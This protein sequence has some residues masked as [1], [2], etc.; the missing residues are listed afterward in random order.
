MAAMTE[1]L[2]LLALGVLFLLGLAVDA[3][4]RRVH[5]P[6]VTL[7]IILGA[8]IGP[9]GLDILPPPLAHADG[10]YAS[11]ALTMVAFLLGGS[12]KLQTLRAHGVRIMVLSLSVVLSSV[13]LVAAGLWLLGMAAGLALLLGAVAAATAPA[14][15]LDVVTQSG[16]N[17]GFSQTLL[18]IVAIDDAWGVFVFSLALAVSASLGMGSDAAWY[19]ELA[20]A[21]RDIGGAIVLGVLIGVP[22][23]MLSGRL[24]PGEPT[25][26]EAVGVVFV[27][28]GLAM[29]LKVSFLLTGMT[30]GAVVVNM[31]RHHEQ[32]FH[33]IERV[34]WP[35]LLLFFVMA[36][37][38]LDLDMLAGLG[39]LGLA[40]VLLRIVARVMGGML[41]NQLLRRPKKEG[42][43][44][45]MALM[46]QAGVAI[47]MA[48]V[49]AE[50]AP[51]WA[52]SLMAVTIAST[53]VFELI[54]PFATQW[55][56][57]KVPLEAPAF[58]ANDAR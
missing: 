48:L 50:R 52:G 33:E 19:M 24:K 55:A 3:V 5:V 4:G 10:L 35:F 21:F 41:G 26:L 57:R 15:T 12:L 32:A 14:A 22:A 11:V 51:T 20:H 27:C 8:L 28:A 46:P 6:R 34:E 37:A 39:W 9:P 7:L 54:G 38:S 53:V 2:L 17:D 1:S 31:A 16:R 43:M 13:V 42:A 49:A 18:G 44:L 40:Y 56:L 23:A 36:G 58:A 47:G 30:C 45:G 25:L 29:M